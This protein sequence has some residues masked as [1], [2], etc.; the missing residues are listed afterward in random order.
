[1]EKIA[2]QPALPGGLPILLE[3]GGFTLR[4]DDPEK[5]VDIASHWDHIT[6]WRFNSSPGWWAE[7]MNYI[8]DDIER[9]IEIKFTATTIDG[10]DFQKTVLFKIRTDGSK[11]LHLEWMQGSNQPPKNAAILPS[12]DN[13]IAVSCAWSMPPARYREDK[14]LHIVDFQ[15]VP[16]TGIDFNRQSAGPMHFVRSSE[17]FRPSESYSNMWYRC[18]VANHGPQPVRGLWV[19]FPVAYNAVV[20]QEN[21]TKSGE[22]I[23][24]GFARGPMLDLAA[25]ESDYFYFANASAAFV[26]VL[27]PTSA[28]LQTMADNTEHEVKVIAS[29]NWQVGLLPSSKPL[30]APVDK[31]SP[32]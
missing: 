11:K 31:V 7:T 15:G 27:P 16:E 29:S 5:F 30:N 1:V 12:L 6:K 10:S 26:T 32:Q 17:P 3:G 21:G 24:A 18:D 23:A 19:K 8:D 20:P 22:M 13:T 2:P 28:T 4:V 14:T 25:G 9:T